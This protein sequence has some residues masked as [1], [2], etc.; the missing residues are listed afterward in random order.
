MSTAALVCKAVG[1]VLAAALIAFFLH[2]KGCGGPT[3][4]M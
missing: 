2:G 1:Y 4:R 3:I